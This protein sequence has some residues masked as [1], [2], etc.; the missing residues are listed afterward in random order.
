M[1]LI[2]LSLLCMVAGD[3]TRLLLILYSFTG[4]DQP[5]IIEA[6]LDIS[7]N[8]IYVT[9]FTNIANVMTIT[10]SAT[11]KASGTENCVTVNWNE[12]TTSFKVDLPADYYV[13]VIAFD[14][15]RQNFTSTPSLVTY[16]VNTKSSVEVKDSLT[17][18]L[19]LPSE[20]TPVYTPTEH[21]TFTSQSLLNASSQQCSQDDKG[22]CSIFSL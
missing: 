4:G 20:K 16:Y 14:N 17:S 10:V 6:F 8:E 9:W 13:T 12:N 15:C 7:T 2:T 21:T 5:Q 11:N 1:F 19:L 22:I 3:K 18:K